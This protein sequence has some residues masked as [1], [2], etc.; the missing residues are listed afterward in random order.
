MPEKGEV[1]KCPH[2]GCEGKQQFTHN[3]NFALASS[4]I[5][6][7]VIDETKK[8]MA[9]FCLKDPTHIDEE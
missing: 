8:P 4:E 2:E 5:R 7:P 9:W 1:R 3:V 6:T